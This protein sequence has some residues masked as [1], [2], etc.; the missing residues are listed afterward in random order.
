MELQL[1][2]HDVYFAVIGARVTSQGATKPQSFALS[3]NRGRAIARARKIHALWR[4]Q[5][6]GLWTLEAYRQAKRIAKGEA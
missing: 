2:L 3:T 4:A 5:P 6:G 1:G